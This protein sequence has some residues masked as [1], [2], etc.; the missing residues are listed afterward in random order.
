MKDLCNDN[1]T[2]KLQEPQVSYESQSVTSIP[3][4]VNR[5]IQIGMEQADKG[6]LI[7]FEEVM[8]RYKKI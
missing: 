7:P 4:Y 8:L 1:G 5:Y 2:D 6:L 3:E